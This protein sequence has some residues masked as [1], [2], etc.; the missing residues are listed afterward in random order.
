M[1]GS[2]FG[3]CFALAAAIV[4]AASLEAPAQQAEPSA[5]PGRLINAGDILSGHLN[6]MR[7]RGGK[8][9]K[10]SN[11]YQLVSEPRRLPPPSG[12]CNLETGPETFQIVANS[13]AQTAQL[14]GFIG[15][16]ISLKVDEV[17]CAEDAGVMSEAVVTKWS[18]VTKH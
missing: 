17:A 7:M 18:V 1:T 6:A 16:D 12:L 15:K 5:K 4:L 9:G 10:R 8:K 2:D 3:K 13:E 14:K 11:T